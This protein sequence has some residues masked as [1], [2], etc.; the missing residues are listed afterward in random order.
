M[1]L[2]D[3]AA[4]DAAQ[5][6]NMLGLGWQVTGLQATGYSPGHTVVVLISVPSGYV[7]ESFALSLSL[8]DSTNEIV[9]LP[10]PAGALQPFRLQ[11]LAKVERPNVAGVHLPADLPGHI[12]LVLNLPQGLP[13][14]AGRLYRWVLEIDGNTNPQWETGFFVAGPPPPTVLG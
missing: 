14:P 2:A 9:Q 11:Q 4:V 6:I 12:Q 5:K 3:Y 13:L 8:R 10:G 1:L 7:G